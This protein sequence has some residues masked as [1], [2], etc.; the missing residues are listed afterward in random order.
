M[1]S[2]EKLKC[3]KTKLVLRYHVPNQNK[4][5]EKY[6]YNILFMF[7]SFRKEIELSLNNSYMNKL[8][9]SGVIEIVNTNKQKLEPYAEVVDTALHNFRNDLIHKQDSFAQQENDEV[10][11]LVTT[12]Y[13]DSESEDEA[14]LFEDSHQDLPVIVVSVMLDEDL[15]QK[16]QSLNNK[17][18]KT[19]DVIHQ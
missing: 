1:S 11:E 17:Q 10:D 7:Y 4:Y 6:A 8:Y 15:N 13:S 12:T 18:R 2:K 3:W 16:I 19:I 14:V 5:P 9:E